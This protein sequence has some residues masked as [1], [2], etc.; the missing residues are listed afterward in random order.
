[1]LR[2]LTEVP[3]FATLVINYKRLSASIYKKENENNPQKKQTNKKPPVFM[4][5]KMENL[6]NLS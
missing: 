4:E 5:L 1:M 6:F 2:I 3:G